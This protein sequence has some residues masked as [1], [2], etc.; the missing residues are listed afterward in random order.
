[1]NQLPSRRYTCACCGAKGRRANKPE[2]RLMPPICP[3]CTYHASNIERYEALAA[4]GR[5][6]ESKITLARPTETNLA[7]IP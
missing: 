2:Q 4:L 6:A 3:R 1:M 7:Y 5:Y